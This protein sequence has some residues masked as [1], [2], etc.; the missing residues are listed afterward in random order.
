MSKDCL[1]LR[2]KDLSIDFGGLKA[3]SSFSCEL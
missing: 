2:V 1:R 3:V